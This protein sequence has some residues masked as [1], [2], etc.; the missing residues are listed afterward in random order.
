MKQSKPV[1]QNVV[2]LGLRD[3]GV[4]NDPRGLASYF[5]KVAAGSGVVMFLF[6]VTACTVIGMAGAAGKWVAMVVAAV[7]VGAPLAIALAATKRGPKVVVRVGPGGAN[8]AAWMPVVMFVL[9]TAMALL[10]GGPLM[11]PLIIVAAFATAGA[12]HGRGRVPAAVAELKAVLAADER[13]LGDALGMVGVGQRDGLRVIVCTDRRVLVAPERRKG[14]WSPL[15]DVPYASVAG[16]GIDWTHAGR[17]G[18]LTLRLAGGETH[19]MGL[20]APMNL[21]S[22]AQA[23][24]THGVPADDPAAVAEADRIRTAPLPPLADLAGMRTREFDRGLWLFLALTTPILYVSLFGAGYWGLLALAAACVACGYVSATKASLMYVVPLVLLQC[25]AFF[26][27]DDPRGVLTHIVMLS[28]V[29]AKGLLLGSAVGGR[30]RRS[31]AAPAAAA[32]PAATAAGRMA[33]GS[34]RTTISGPSLIRLTGMM[35][36]VTAVLIVLAGA[37]GFEMINVRLAI[38]EAT[39]TRLAVD[40]RSDLTGGAA[41]LAYTPGP[42]LRE[43]VTDEEWGAG[44]NDGAR[45]EL[46]SSFMRGHNVVS[47]A[48]Y[49]FEPRLDNPK[50]V[51]DFVAA[52]DAEHAALAGHR[53]KHTERTVDGRTG[54]VW[55]HGNHRGYWHYAVWFPHPVH[56][57]RVECIAKRQEKQFKRLCFDALASL[58]FAGP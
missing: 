12:W 25:P 7:V 55:T 14:A 30:F 19:A 46:R 26:F 56:T 39:S 41:A 45:W 2:D 51:A 49:V 34:L 32:A 27:T 50:A 58:R 10:I 15:V 42:G 9:L 28:V 31:T 24:E 23:L 5:G 3:V 57:I 36:A 21:L 1:F 13:V 47:L 8:A 53:V 48:H 54:Y 6:L 43:L 37:T 17:F 18:E 52:K 33:V 44:P 35:V 11:A 20:I 16:F 38:E 4:E 40:G 29:A 22:I